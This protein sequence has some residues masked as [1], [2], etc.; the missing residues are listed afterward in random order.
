MTTA[1]EDDYEEGFWRPA[2][3][4]YEEPI[5]EYQWECPCNQCAGIGPADYDLEPEAYEEDTD[6]A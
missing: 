6:E 3:E 1:N 5:E 4:Y 2:D